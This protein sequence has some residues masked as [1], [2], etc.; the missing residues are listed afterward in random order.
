MAF[1]QL[2]GVNAVLAY[3]VEIFQTAG[4][5][6]NPYLCT[7]IF[8]VVQLVSTLIPIFIV[9]RVGRR[10]LLIIS[11]AGMGVCLLAMVIRFYVLHQGIEI[12][13]LDWLPLIAVNL[14]VV[15]FSVGLGSIPWFMMP[16]LL[17]NEARIWVS[18]KAVCLNW[19]MAF[20]VTKF[21]LI[22]LNVWGSEATYG[23][24]FFVCVVGTIFVVVFVPE[25]TRKTRE[26]VLTQLSN[27]CIFVTGWHKL[28]E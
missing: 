8:G 5:A 17:S 25:T 10:I 19:L 23:T 26:E 27:H 24:L 13:Y 7:V 22:M 15:A 20:L 3:T 2:C 4:S 18:S 11:C 6:L 16:E 9:D 1:R 28:K 12:K 21:F 14:Y